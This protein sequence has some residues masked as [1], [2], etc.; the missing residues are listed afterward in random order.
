MSDQIASGEPIL[1]AHSYY[2]NIA[3]DESVPPHE[4]GRAIYNYRC[5]FCHA[6]SGDA[7]TQ[8]ATYLKPKPRNFRT[9]DPIKLSRDKMLEVV[10]LG[11]PDTAMKSF[12]AWLTPFE[13]E[14]VVD[15]IRAEF[16]LNKRQN[17]RYHTKA[18]GWP[19]HEKYMLAFPFA[20]GE[21]A[22]DTLEENLTEQQRKG[23]ELFMKSC[24]T[25]H[26][27]GKV[28]DEGEV[29]VSKAVSYPRNDY[30]HRSVRPDA[31]SEASVFGKHDIKPII[32]NLTDEEQQGETLFQDGCAFCHG[33]AGTGKNWIGSFLEPK[34]RDLTNPDEMAGMTVSRL[35][36]A[37]E[38]GVVDTKMPAWKSVLNAEQIAALV[39]YIN[40]AFYPLENE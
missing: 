22:T 23:F 38:N 35:T 28:I 18:N 21:I 33:M 4:R 13:M 8:A 20:I 10:A 24:V 36:Y 37:I 3:E 11:K 29:W 31:I 34:P 19:E 32:D 6:Y 26:D 17:T 25:C 2:P 27:R 39:A 9:S 7:V 14:L 1:V 15:F 5:Y 16:M 40:R 12:E 30:S